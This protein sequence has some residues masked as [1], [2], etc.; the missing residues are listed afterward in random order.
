MGIARTIRIYKKAGHASNSVRT[1]DEGPGNRVRIKDVLLRLDSL[2]EEFAD[3]LEAQTRY[4][5]KDRRKAASK[6]HTSVVV[7]GFPCLESTTCRSFSSSHVSIVSVHTPNT[8][9][10]PYNIPVLRNRGKIENSPAIFS[11]RLSAYK[12]FF[13]T[14]LSISLS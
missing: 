13:S 5:E 14:F 1:L 12:F 8:V 9:S 11:S 10:F 2:D 7:F 3:N 4:Q 6:G